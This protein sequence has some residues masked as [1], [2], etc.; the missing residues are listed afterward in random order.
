[1]IKIFCFGQPFMWP[2]IW[3]G[4]FSEQQNSTFV[5]RMCGAV[6]AAMQQS[7][8]DWSH[9]F[10]AR[11]RSHKLIKKCSPRL[12]HPPLSAHL[13]HLCILAER[14]GSQGQ[15]RNPGEEGEGGWWTALMATISMKWPSG[16]DA[17]WAC[18]TLAWT[19]GWG[20]DRVGI[21]RNEG[22]SI[23]RD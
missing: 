15:E 9:L 2:V 17:S 19:H 5:V 8:G 23:E 4:P 11:S 16:S 22:G 18:C 14:V 1:M 7:P 13:L 21:S 12:M 20:W 3:W 6:Y 10:G